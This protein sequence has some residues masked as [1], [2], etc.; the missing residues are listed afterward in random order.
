MVEGALFGIKAAVLVIVI[1]ALI[2]I[3]KRSLKTRLLAGVAGS[4]FVGIFFLDLPFPLIV[5]PPPQ[6]VISWP[7]APDRVGLKNEKRI[8]AV[9]NRRRHLPAPAIGLILWWA[10]V[11]LAALAGAGPCTGRYRHV[12]LEARGG[13]FRRR[14]RAP[15]VHGAA[16]GRDLRLDDG[17]RDGGGLGVAETM[18]GPLIKVTQFVG[19]LRRSGPPS[20]SLR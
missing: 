3:G 18:P 8:A 2:R 16:G 9:P 20:P 13:Q 12:F 5:V 1:E 4:A 19:F 6:S 11:A 10:P 15:L 7:G 17:T 14:L